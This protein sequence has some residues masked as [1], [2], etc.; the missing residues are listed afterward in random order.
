LREIHKLYLIRYIY[1]LIS[2]EKS[3]NL[4]KITH[5]CHKRNTDALLMFYTTH[6]SMDPLGSFRTAPNLLAL[7]M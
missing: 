5:I 7:D 2:A 6:R 3:I 4:K 1:D